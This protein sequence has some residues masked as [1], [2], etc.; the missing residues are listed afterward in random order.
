ML[1][2]VSQSVSLDPPYD[3][4][5][6][7]HQTQKQPSSGTSSENRISKPLRLIILTL[8]QSSR[9]SRLR[10]G[11]RSVTLVSL[12]DVTAYL[13]TVCQHTALCNMGYSLTAQGNI[14][15]QMTGHRANQPQLQHGRILEVLFS[16][17]GRHTSSNNMKCEL[18]CFVSADGRLR[19]T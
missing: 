11:Q 1:H 3:S 9:E 4:G 12:G 15:Q 10:E 13:S 19:N 18:R 17:L 5:L 7:L 16:K 2:G 14:L 8:F 6:V